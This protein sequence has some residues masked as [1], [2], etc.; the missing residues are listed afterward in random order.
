MPW[1]DEPPWNAKKRQTER[2]E[3]IAKVIDAYRKGDLHYRQA[4]TEIDEIQNGTGGPVA[5]IGEGHN[6]EVQSDADV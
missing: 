4:L 6:P 5:R 1:H 3:K 2:I